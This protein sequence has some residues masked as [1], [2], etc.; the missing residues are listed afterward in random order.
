MIKST[1][2]ILND[3]M[4]KMID[5]SLHINKILSTIP[6]SYKI[7]SFLKLISTNYSSRNLKQFSFQEKVKLSLTS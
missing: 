2:A 5:E 3:S 1:F 7:D 4:P 6:F